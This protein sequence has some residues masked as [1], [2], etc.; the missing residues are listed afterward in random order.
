[1]ETQIIDVCRKLAEAGRWDELKQQLTQHFSELPEPSQV[2]V[3]SIIDAMVAQAQLDNAISTPMLERVE[4]L[5]AQLA[6]LDKA[7]TAIDEAVAKHEVR[8]TLSQD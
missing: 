1:M 6:E 7:D 5:Y 3:D 2:S 4:Y 8:K